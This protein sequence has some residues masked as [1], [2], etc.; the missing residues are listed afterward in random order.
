MNLGRKMRA[1]ALAGAALLFLLL[2]LTL[3]CQAQNSSS[4][5]SSSVV[6]A[7]LSQPKYPLIALQ[8]RVKGDVEVELGIRPD[9]GV[10]Y[11]KVASGPPL[12]R[13][14]ALKSARESSFE[15]VACRESVTSYQLV[16]TFEISMLAPSSECGVTATAPPPR[17]AQTPNHVTL[18]EYAAGKYICDSFPIKRRSIRCLY[19]WRCGS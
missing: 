15:C 9:G 14:A 16:Y 17:V 19:L 11:A 5:A 10:D 12:L 6:L 13:E 1:W 3:E 8:G 4:P 2:S 18:T 7:K